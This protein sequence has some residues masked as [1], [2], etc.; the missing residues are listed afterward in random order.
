MAHA[1]AA[2]LSASGGTAKAGGG[3]GCEVPDA[4][5]SVAP[6]MEVTDRHFRTLARLIS[7]RVTLY[8]EMV[9]DRTLIHNAKARAL[10]LRIPPIP[11]QGGRPISQHPVVLQLGG[12]V[13]EELE[14][15]ARIAAEYG[16]TEVN[17]NCGCP[18]P[19]VAGKGCFGAALMRTPETVAEATRRMAAVLP[20][21]TPVTV[22]CRLGVDDDDSYESLHRFV[23]IVST[24]GPV[25]HFI[26]HARKA[27]LG[28]LSPAANRTVPP[29][30]PEYVYRLREDFPH[31]T[32]SINGGLRS[33][34]QVQSELDKG[35]H[36]VMVGRGVMDNP[37][38][39][40][41]DV[42]MVIYGE[43]PDRLHGEPLTRRNVVKRYLEYAELEMDASG[44]PA[45]ALVRPLLNL[46]TGEPNGK[47]FRRIIDEGLKNP[48]KRV[49]EVVSQALRILADDVLD[50]PP[51][52]LWPPPE[53]SRQDTVPHPIV[54]ESYNFVSANTASAPMSAV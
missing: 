29:L 24:G 41:C 28:G 18:S 40:L 16:Y 54:D 37:W 27:I 52:S 14:A 49:T 3:R 32:F 50:R 38:E 11:A 13:P 51:P 47:R 26:I 17:L 2:A 22:K 46:F 35:V 30:R 7:R 39:A 34:T 21:S 48:H 42:D 25:S 20:V 19:K 9:V 45:R 1:R 15:G 43:N 4:A 44:A 10:E 12:S 53:A 36:G 33:I 8:T 31:L 5:Y 23:R 6:M